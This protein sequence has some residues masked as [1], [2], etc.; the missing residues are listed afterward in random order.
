MVLDRRTVRSSFDELTI[1]RTKL[2]NVQF[3]VNPPNNN[4]PKPFVTGARV[5]VSVFSPGAVHALDRRT[6][7]IIW[8]RDIPE[9]GGSAVLLSRNHL[10]A[11]TANTVYALKSETGE[12][13]WSFCPYGESGESIYSSPTIYANSLFIGDRRGYL[14]CLDSTTGVARW[15]V[16]TNRTANCDVNSTPIVI[17][18]LVIVATNAN[19]A[20]AYDARSGKRI[21]I[22]KL[23]GPSTSGPFKCGKFVA[24]FTDS[25]YFIEPDSG[26]V[27]RRFSWKDDG[28]SNAAAVRIGIV[29]SLRGS[30][31]PAGNVKFV[32]VNE[33]KVY[34]TVSHRTFVAFLQYVA[35]TDLIYVSHLEGIDIIRPN[36]GSIVCKLECESRPPG[37]GPVDVKRRRIHVLTNEGYVYALRH[38]TVEQIGR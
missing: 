25:I 5:C 35:E 33:D 28:V 8:S 18:G 12:T 16:R 7:E 22:R 1:W 27:V 9:F 23:D 29:A 14:H 4:R 10:L 13:A 34:F 19:F 3:A 32:G 17:K 30:W 36:D 20:A 26:K 31:P 38:P 15:K 21:W 11:Q 37:N 24:L 6:G 2:P